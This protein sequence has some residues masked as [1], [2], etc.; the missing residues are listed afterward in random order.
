[1]AYRDDAGYAYFTGRLGDWMRVDGENLGTAAI[2][3]W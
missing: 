2:N 1:L 3:P